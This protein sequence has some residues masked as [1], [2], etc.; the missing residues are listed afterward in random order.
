MKYANLSLA[1]LKA[2]KNQLKRWTHILQCNIFSSLESNWYDTVVS[3]HKITQQQWE[4]FHIPLRLAQ[5]IH[6]RINPKEDSCINIS[7][8]KTQQPIPTNLQKSY[9]Q[10]SNSSEVEAFEIKATC[11]IILL[12]EE[13]GKES[14][15]V[16]MTMKT[17]ISNIIECPSEEIKRHLKKANKIIY[18]RIWKNEGSLEFFVLVFALYSA[19]LNM[20]TK[21]YT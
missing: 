2:L 7:V 3:L 13:I 14:L 1:L 12:K 16:F 15:K 5:L 4:S 11:L 21:D 9:T 8:S 6:D 20:I 19:G 17:I 18:E 10:S